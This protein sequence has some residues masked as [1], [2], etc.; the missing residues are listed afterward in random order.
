MRLIYFLAWITALGGLCTY[1]VRFGL[2]HLYDYRVG[3]DGIEFWIFASR[4]I[5]IIQFDRIEDVFEQAF[6]KLVDGKPIS[7]F[8]GLVIGNR[9]ATNYVVVKMKTG[10]F[11]YFGL[12][13]IDRESFVAQVKRGLNRHSNA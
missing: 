3:E 7:M 8:R 1:L 2:S 6:L 11:R 4:R 5:F 12:T 9:L 10:F 13:P